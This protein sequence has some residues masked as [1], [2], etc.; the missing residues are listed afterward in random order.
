MTERR[1]FLA[2]LV[3]GT[4]VA[5]SG[6]TALSSAPKNPP[7]SAREISVTDATCEPSPTHDTQVGFLEEESVVEFSGT[8]VGHATCESLDVGVYTAQ[9]AEHADDVGI[10]VIPTDD[11]DGCDPC[12]ARLTYRGRVEFAENSYPTGVD[13]SHMDSEDGRIVYAERFTR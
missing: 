8:I 12:T 4:G 9:T 7:Q 1:P 6:C 3:A 2:T 11:T 5:L 13:L 10:R